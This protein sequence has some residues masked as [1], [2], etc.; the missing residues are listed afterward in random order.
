MK[1]FYVY[2]L[3]L[4]TIVLFTSL[5]AFGQS[6]KLEEGTQIRLKLMQDI[7]SATSQVGQ[8]ITFETLDSVKV[9]NVTV[10]AEGAQALGTI[11]EAQPKKSLGRGGKLNFRLEYVKAVDGSK[12]PIRATSV[13]QGNGKGVAT[14]VAVGVSAL[15]F[16]PAAPAF[17]LIK[18][19][20]ITVPRGQHLDAFIDGTK[21]I[22]IPQTQNTPFATTAFPT[23]TTTSYSNVSTNSN[24]LCVVSIISEKG[25]DIEID[26]VF[27]G[28]A[29]ATFQ[30][31]AG[32]HTVTVKRSGFA[33]WVRTITIVPGNITLRVEF[34]GIRTAR[35][36]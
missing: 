3:G 2:L 8:T 23:T 6:I 10:I 16:F 29:P 22:D 27:L 21:V 13:N 11:V 15:V 31:P 19:K 14:G 1:N 34:E 4:V 7:S 32:T 28:S 9:D 5:T 36:R 24:K 30:L 17:L 35:R 20:D 26:G 25:G 18:G 12:I 33:P